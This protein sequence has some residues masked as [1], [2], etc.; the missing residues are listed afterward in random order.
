M[1]TPPP[2]PGPAAPLADRLESATFAPPPPP[3]PPPSPSAI[4]SA[5]SRLREPSSSSPAVA[6]AALET[7]HLH[8][9]ALRLSS[10]HVALLLPLLPLHPRLVAPLLATSPHLLPASLPDS[11]PVSPRLLLLGA[12]AF[13]KSA[14]DPPS[15]ASL[16]SATAKN[17]GGGESASGH[18]DDPVL[19]V[20]RMLEDVEQGGQSIDDL[21]HLALAG[22]GYALASADEVQFRRILVSLLRICGRIGNLAVGVRVL[23]LVEWLVMGFV[24]SRK[25]RKVQ[26]LF[27][28]IS[29]ET[30]ESE[31]YVLFPVVMAACGGLRA[32]RVASARYRLDFD[33]RLKEAPERTIRFAAERVVL[34]GRPA[35]DQHILVQCVTL[36]LTQC[37][38]VMF[39]EPVLQCICMGLLKELL[40][41]PGMLRMSV[42]S[43]E[44]N[45]AD[46]VKAKV[47]QHLDSVLFKEAGPV[48][49]VLCNHYSYA[50]SMAKEFVETC[51]WEYAQEIYCHL[52]AAVLLHRGKQDD[53]ITAI[54][55]IAEA[56]FLMV[57]VFAAEVTKHRLI[58][59]SLEGF[60]PE[61]AAKI[62]VAFSCVEHLRRLRLPE[63]TEAVR[64]AVLANQEN[65][66]AV[67]LFIESMP[68][69]A[70]LTSQPDFPSL[71]GTRYIWHKD[72]VQ[73]SRILFY[74]RVVPTCVGLIPAH[75]IRDKVASIMFLY[76]QH[77]NEK[78][79]S[80]SHSVMVSFL[81][82]GNDADQDDRTIL[83][84]QLIFYYIKRSLEAYP[85]VTPFDGL[86]SGVA[87]IVRHIP[88]GSPAILFCIHSLVVK[89]KD[90]CDTAKVQDKS[91]WRS[92]EE[93][94]EP[95]KKT[96]DLLLRLIFLVDIQSFPYL[97]KE[98]AEFVTLLP[99]EGQDA[100]LDDMHAHVAESDDV[101]RKPVLVSWLQ[102]LSYI[103]SQWSRSES[104]SKATNASSVASDELTLNRTMARL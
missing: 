69:Y 21:D 45:A 19:A 38:R 33:P 78:V 90:L 65:A 50:G 43:V 79:T 67:T 100:L 20:G 57:V 54:D 27:E 77:S 70:E 36:G 95:C 11:L 94:T 15:G 82:S 80:A 97:L 98:L 3:P 87:A 51:V 72:E 88:A 46:V 47:N 42:E 58:A 2:R 34:E 56:S 13:A 81:S 28:M 91:L 29:P 103:S 39:H 99:K 4:L 37:G 7:L 44:G 35:D 8:R 12:R 64:R 49:G 55:K 83:K 26:V 22:I 9:R 5:W 53:L 66:A 25:M 68:S 101:T 59:K 76:L 23:K 104:H 17:L 89:A 31:G 61:V 84:E 41:L 93:S 1:A 60:Q 73:T 75:M 24:E 18:D 16:G 92:W 102:S 74:L 30:C 10:A 86:A 63:Y 52:R 85:G 6:L 96:L 14:K 62:L 48:T 71:A 32:L 40:P